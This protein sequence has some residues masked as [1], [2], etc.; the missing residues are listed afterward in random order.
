MKKTRDF[1]FFAIYL[2]NHCRNH[3]MGKEVVCSFHCQVIRYFFFLSVSFY[4]TSDLNYT[5]TLEITHYFVQLSA[6]QFSSSFSVTV[7]VVTQ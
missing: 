4:T 7:S 5:T 1:F 3:A 2:V 6:R